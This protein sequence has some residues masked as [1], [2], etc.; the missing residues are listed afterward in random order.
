MKDKSRI[1]PVLFAT[2]EMVTEASVKSVFYP[3]IKLGG[4]YFQ[5]KIRGG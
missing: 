1:K 5:L 2:L 4:V 3:G